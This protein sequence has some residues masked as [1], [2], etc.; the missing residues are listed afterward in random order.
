MSE[1]KNADIA[2]DGQLTEH[3]NLKEFTCSCCDRVK[4]TPGFFRHV[5]LL[6]Q[7]RTKLGFPIRINSGY[8]C[9]EHNKAVGGAK[10]SWHLL[11]ATDLD[12]DDGDPEKLT[13]IRMAAE[14]AGFTG[15]GISDTFIH[16]DLRPEKTIWRYS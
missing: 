14:E 1:T 16:V 9:P 10:S 8:R 6:E 5:G 4:I 11:F 2:V 13:A 7:I 12:T 3:F 15:I